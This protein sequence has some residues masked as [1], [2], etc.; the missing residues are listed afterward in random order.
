LKKGPDNSRGKKRYAL[1]F[2]CKSSLRFSTKIRMRWSTIPGRRVIRIIPYINNP[3]PARLAIP[4]T[5]KGKNELLLNNA[6]IQICLY[7]RVLMI[8]RRK[9]LPMMIPNNAP[10]KIICDKVEVLTG[11]KN[12][13]LIRNSI[14]ATINGSNE[15]ILA[16]YLG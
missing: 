9:K 11:S 12:P 16:A 1:F 7:V 13:G 4:I 8:R 5:N 15:R 3:T 10:I 14:R 2:G 6:V